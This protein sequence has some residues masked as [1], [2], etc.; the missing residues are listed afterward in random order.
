LGRA[1]AYDEALR[2]NEAGLLAE[3]LARNLFGNAEKPSNAVEKVTN[4]VIQSSQALENA[5]IGDFY[6]AKLPF[7]AVIDED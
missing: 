5:V 7:F 1:S 2:K 6:S 4:Y 3:A